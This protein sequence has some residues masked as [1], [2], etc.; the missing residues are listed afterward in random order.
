MVEE[1]FRKMEIDWKQRSRKLWLQEGDAYMR[2]FH[3]LAN[4]R[5]KSDQI[6]RL[7][8]ENQEYASTEAMGCALAD[9]FFYHFP[10]KGN[11][12]CGN[13]VIGGK[14]WWPRNNRQY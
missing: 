2:F 11:K 8:V 6:V 4:R 3:I 10:R 5:R 14:G 7:K 9:H 1:K 12:T 13:G